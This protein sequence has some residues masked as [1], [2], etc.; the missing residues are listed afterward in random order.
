MEDVRGNEGVRMSAP[1]KKEM[2]MSTNA[3]LLQK[4]VRFH[5]MMVSVSEDENMGPEAMR[6]LLIDELCGYQ[7]K[8]DYNQSDPLQPPKER[9][10]GKIGGSC[11]DHC[12]AFQVCYKSAEKWNAKSDFYSQLKPLYQ[13]PRD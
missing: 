2:W 3:L 10:T 11:D 5:P 1:F 7:R 12:I 8:L 6:K 9:F 13:A 4:K